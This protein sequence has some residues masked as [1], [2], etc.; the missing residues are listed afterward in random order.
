MHLQKMVSRFQS[1][2]G[3][4]LILTPWIKIHDV[5]LCCW[6]PNGVSKIARKVSVPLVVDG[7]T[8]NKV[9]LTFARVCVEFDKSNPLLE[10][11]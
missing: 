9:I 8:T 6:N 5:P 11:N 7:L 4:V 10:K 1:Y 2:Q 3:K